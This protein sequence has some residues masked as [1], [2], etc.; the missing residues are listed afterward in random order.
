MI[1]LPMGPACEFVTVGGHRLAIYEC[2][3]PEVVR[4]FDGRRDF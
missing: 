4:N 2:T 1:E 3:R